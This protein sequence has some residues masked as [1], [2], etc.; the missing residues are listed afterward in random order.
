MH[1]STE[2]MTLEIRMYI[3]QMVF[4]I[5]LPVHRRI[6]KPLAVIRWSVMILEE[7]FSNSVGSVFNNFHKDLSF[8]DLQKEITNINHRKHYLIKLSNRTNWDSLF[9]CLIYS[10]ILLVEFR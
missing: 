7:V 4:Q 2:I 9:K 1:G 10:N 5:I 8:S 6:P 3:I